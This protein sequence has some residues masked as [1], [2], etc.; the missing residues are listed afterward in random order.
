VTNAA[1]PGHL[2][3]SSTVGAHANFN[4]PLGIATDN[5]RDFVD[6]DQLADSARYTNKCDNYFLYSNNKCDTT[7]MI[8]QSHKII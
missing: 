6:G 8:L 7:I 1:G 4:E 3:S 2:P 5:S